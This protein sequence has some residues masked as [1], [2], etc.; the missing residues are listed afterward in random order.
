MVSEQKA[1]NHGHHGNYI[2]NEVSKAFVKE[3]ESF[4]KGE[5]VSI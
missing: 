3:I 4:Y 2:S 5:F 1:I